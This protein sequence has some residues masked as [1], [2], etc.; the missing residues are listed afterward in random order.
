[1]KIKMYIPEY[2]QRSKDAIFVRNPLKD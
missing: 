2:F 1:V